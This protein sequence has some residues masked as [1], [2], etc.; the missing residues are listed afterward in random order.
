M[1]LTPQQNTVAE[2]AL[3]DIEQERNRAYFTLPLVD[4]SGGSASDAAI[5][6][7]RPGGT[8]ALAIDALRRQLDRVDSG[9]MSW[10]TWCSNAAN[11]RKSIQDVA[12]Y[13]DDWSMWGVL[14]STG[15]AT[16]G[17]V[18]AKV[19]QV[20]TGTGIGIGLVLGLLI[21]WKLS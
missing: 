18:K 21:L 12:G 1:S 11:L 13:G 19:D 14:V 4:A 7:L 6:Y 10:S 17:D 9:A 8:A 2:Q 5:A 15:E 16:A 20:G 3:D